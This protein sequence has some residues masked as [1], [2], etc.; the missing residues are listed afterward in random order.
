MLQRV[1]GYPAFREAQVAPLAAIL[2]G[3]DVLAV[4]PTGGGKSLLYQV[5]ALVEGGLTLVVTPL[6]ALMHDQVAHLKRRGVPAALLD[7]TLAR[8]RAEQVLIN[9]QHGAYRLLYVSPERL[10]TEL[11][12]G[13]R[14]A[15][16][17]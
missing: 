5:P 10:E 15:S 17:P 2:A 8:R 13:L 9:A 11:F 3:R 6:V 12:L 4:L 7:Y 1:W 16:L 14:A